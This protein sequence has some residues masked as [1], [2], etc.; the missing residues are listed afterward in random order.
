MT[1]NLAGKII[2]EDS[3]NAPSNKENLELKK[4]NLQDS[5]NKSL[6]SIFRPEFLNR[7]DEVVKFEPLSIDQLQKIILLQIEDLKKLLLEQ[8]INISIEKKVILKIANDSYEPEYGARPL[9]RELRRQIENPL[10]SKLLE[11]SYKN[12]KNII[13]KINPS[14]KDEILFKPS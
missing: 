4:Q 10:A 6:S 14:K 1:S 13:V 2:L 12:K 7:I 9:S 3:K 11:E 5:I 8:G